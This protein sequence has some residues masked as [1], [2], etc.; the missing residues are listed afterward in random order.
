VNQLLQQLAR[1]LAR[2][3]AAPGSLSADEVLAR[4]DSA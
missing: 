2:A 1:E 4:L 3:G